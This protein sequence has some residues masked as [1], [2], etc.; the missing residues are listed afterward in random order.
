VTRSELI[1]KLAA[2]NTALYHRDIERLVGTMLDEIGSALERGDRVELR[3]F[4]AFSVRYRKSR[5]GRNPRTGTSVKVSE[6]KV[7]FFKMGKGM[8][9]RLNR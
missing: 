5:V 7:P 8:R 6:K 1:A 2:K 9:E 3:G 4:G